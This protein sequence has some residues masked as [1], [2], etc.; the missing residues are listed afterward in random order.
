MI[1]TITA[2]HNAD[3]SN[4]WD[5]VTAYLIQFAIFAAIWWAVIPIRVPTDSQSQKQT[6]F[7][8]TDEL[9]KYLSGVRIA[10][11]DLIHLAAF[12]VISLVSLTWGSIPIE[13]AFLLMTPVSIA[14]TIQIY[15]TPDWY[16]P[17][18][19]GVHAVS[20]GAFPYLIMSG[21]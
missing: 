13:I 8:S 21:F 18:R 14:R 2:I 17:L 19:I 16:A 5:V 7:G 6:K 10:R 12:I 20:I 11:A 15:E 9:L 4:R 3:F 1:A